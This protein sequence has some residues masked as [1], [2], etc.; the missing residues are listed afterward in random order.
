MYSNFGYIKL[1][2]QYYLFLKC[3]RLLLFWLDYYK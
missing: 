3:V 2:P 1:Y